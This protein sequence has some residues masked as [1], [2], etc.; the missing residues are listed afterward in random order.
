MTIAAVERAFKLLEALADEFY[1][2]TVRYGFMDQPDIPA[3]LARLRSHGLE[4]PPLETSY[5][6]SRETLIPSL[7]KEG[8][9]LWRERLFATMARNAGSVTA[10]FRLPTHRVVELGTQIEL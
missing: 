6:L 1:R 5:F 2:I 8:M 3:A 10:Y 7:A 4:F 9:A